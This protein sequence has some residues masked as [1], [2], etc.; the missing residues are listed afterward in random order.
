MRKRYHHYG[1]AEGVQ[2]VN[3]GSRPNHANVASRSTRKRKKRGWCIAGVVIIIFAGIALYEGYFAVSAANNILSSNISLK[4]LISKS[5]LKQTDGRTNILL[6][7]KGGDNHDGGQLTDTIQI[8]S[9]NRSDNRVALISLPRDLQI[10]VPGGGI[11]KLNYAYADGY[12]KEKDPNKKGDAGAQEASQ[13]ISKIAGIPLHYYITLDFI[14]FK[15][16]VDNIGGVTVDVPKNLD[17]P[18]Y[19]KDTITTSGQFVETNAYSP[20]HV[21]AGAQTMNGDLALKYARSRETTSDFDRSARQQIVML[22]IKDKATS[23]GVLSNPVKVTE[24]LT[25]LGKHVKTNLNASELK[26]FIGI[27]KNFQKD[28][29]INKVIDNN[30]KDG[31]LVSVDQGGYYLLP[32]SG[33]FSEVQQVV[34]NIFS[35]TDSA[36]LTPSITVLNGSGRTGLGGQLAQALKDQGLT[37]DQIGTDTKI[38][39]QSTI[40][41]GTG[42]SKALTTIK[43]HFT[44]PKIVQSDTKG[45]IKIVIGQDYGK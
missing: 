12:M 8:M 20:L 30:P 32:K 18:F 33:N 23:L 31:L 4:D 36:N 40:Y 28:N 43:A 22:A 26:D 45:V 27:A 5:D 1:H 11:N 15:D 13:V 29:M 25:T 41:D 21:K 38:S 39:A 17:D 24:I 2:H 6:L 35:T 7:G 19:P 14:G 34:K 37:I 10:T 44:N 42:S 3:I 9:I 16:L